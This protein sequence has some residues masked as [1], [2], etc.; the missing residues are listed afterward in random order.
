MAWRPGCQPVAPPTPPGE[1]AAATW[2]GARD[3]SP[4]EHVEDS[5][6]GLRAP[7]VHGSASPTGGTLGG[8]IHGATYPCDEEWSAFPKSGLYPARASTRARVLRAIR[9]PLPPL[10]SSATLSVHER[11]SWPSGVGLVGGHRA[12][13][14]RALPGAARRPDADALRAAV[15]NRPARPGPTG[16]R[17]PHGG[18]GPLRQRCGELYCLACLRCIEGEDGET[19]DTPAGENR[20]VVFSSTSRLVRSMLGLSDADCRHRSRT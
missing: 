1:T 17:S 3:S 9:S 8:C 6:R 13:H 14:A 19:S 10:Y 7:G 20:S 11:V 16:T 18:D 4:K 12:L 15:F 5:A 2:G